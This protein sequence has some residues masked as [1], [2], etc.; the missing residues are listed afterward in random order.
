MKAVAGA[1]LFCMI[2]ASPMTVA[3]AGDVS[4]AVSIAAPVTGR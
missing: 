1:F 4:K 2:A 3:H